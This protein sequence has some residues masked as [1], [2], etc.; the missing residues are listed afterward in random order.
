MFAQYYTPSVGIELSSIHP[1]L[2]AFKQPQEESQERTFE[3]GEK[4]RDMDEVKNMSERGMGGIPDV[5]E[6]WWDGRSR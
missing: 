3:K 2:Q 1:P 5:L 4:P 6:A